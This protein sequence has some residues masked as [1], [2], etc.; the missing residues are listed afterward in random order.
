MR[1]IDRPAIYKF[2]KKLIEFLEKNVS[3]E[4]VRTLVREYGVFPEK[5]YENHRDGNFYGWLGTKLRGQL[6]PFYDFLGENIQ[7]KRIL[8]LGCGSHR[9]TYESRN[10]DPPIWEPWLCRALTK[11][12]A[13]PIGV[14]IGDLSEERFEHYQINLLSENSLNIIPDNSID[15][16]N[17][18]LLYDSPTL[19]EMPGGR[20][21]R[22]LL[23]PQL[24]RVIKPEGFFIEG[25]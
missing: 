15:I 13:N 20:N 17:A 24:E 16:T 19:Q 22:D 10:W 2:D 18:E 3:E 25:F 11:L 14:D 21:L 12:G 1:I 9:G 4:F 8:D 5:E 7:N 6:A 23:I